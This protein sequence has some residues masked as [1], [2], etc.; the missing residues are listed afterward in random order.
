M[1][2][3]LSQIVQYVALKPELGISGEVAMMFPFLRL[4]KMLIDII[5][6]L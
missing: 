2:Q 1:M 6:I 3:T 5:I 4:Y